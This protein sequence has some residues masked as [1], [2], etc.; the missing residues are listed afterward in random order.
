VVNMTVP[1]GSQFSKIT[2]PSRSNNLPQRVDRYFFE[3]KFF[4]VGS[5]VL[6]VGVP[7]VSVSPGVFL[8][9]S[10]AAR[11]VSSASSRTTGSPSNISK[12]E[13]I[14]TRQASLITRP[15]AIASRV[16]KQMRSRNPARL[17]GGA[18]N[19]HQPAQ[20]LRLVGAAGSSTSKGKGFDRRFP[21][22]F[23]LTHVARILLL[24]Q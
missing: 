14:L 5:S 15:A 19:S 12:G 9:A 17:V 1:S 21:L 24:V 13:S 8:S 23:E 22:S 18:T 6:F 4:S 7:A 11:R 16:K 20:R 3:I 2:E 10:I